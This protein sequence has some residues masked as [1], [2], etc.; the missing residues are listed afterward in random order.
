M[1]DK[2]KME[3]PFFQVPN[4][5][6]DIGLSRVEM[7]VYLYLARCC[8]GGS[9][10]FPSYPTIAKKCSMTKPTAIEA[11]KQLERYQLLKKKPRQSKK[12]EESYS[13]MYTVVCNF[14]VNLQRDIIS[15]KKAE[16]DRLE[17]KGRGMMEAAQAAGATPIKI[18]RKRAIEVGR[19]I[20]EGQKKEKGKKKRGMADGY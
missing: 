18:T 11:V 9:K 19:Q 4:S 15:G 10:A 12:K 16:E 2:I 7:L 6:F 17:R 20:E 13:N 14:D 3:V 8:N 5:I 1:A